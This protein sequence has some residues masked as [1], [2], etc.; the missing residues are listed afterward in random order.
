MAYPDVVRQQKRLNA[1]DQ[2]RA[3]ILADRHA[4]HAALVDNS[5]AAVR[6]QAEITRLQGP[7]RPL[8]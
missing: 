4:D 2:Q 6:A 7:L 3:V 1:L 8:R 5:I